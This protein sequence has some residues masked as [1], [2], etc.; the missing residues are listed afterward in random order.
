MTQIGLSSLF[1]SHNY[2]RVKIM[3]EQN[4]NDQELGQK[5]R[6]YF[7]SLTKDDLQAKPKK[8]AVERDESSY[9]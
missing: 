7:N 4:P 6:E 9:F 5:I 1:L 3:V 8:S 2:Y